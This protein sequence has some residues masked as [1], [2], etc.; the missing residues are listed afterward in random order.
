MLLS[1]SEE[2][3]SISDCCMVLDCAENTVLSYELVSGVL[4][5][6]WKDSN[7]KHDLMHV[8]MSSRYVRCF[9]VN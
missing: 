7:G 4:F 5:V 3:G 2:S 9:D 1:V 6:L 8:S